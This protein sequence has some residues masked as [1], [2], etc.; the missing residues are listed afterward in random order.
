MLLPRTNILVARVIAER[1]R[2]EIEKTTVSNEN[3]DFISCTASIGLAVSSEKSSRDWLSV[4]DALLYQAK[5]NG[6]N[7]IRY[8]EGRVYS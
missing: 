2:M 1:I 8:E 7:C 5:R 3:N 6:R 4:C